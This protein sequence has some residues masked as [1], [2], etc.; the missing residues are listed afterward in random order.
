MV[1]TFVLGGFLWIRSYRSWDRVL[2]GTHGSGLT[3]VSDVGK[4][5]VEYSHSGSAFNFFTFDIGYDS[6][7]K[8]KAMNPALRGRRDQVSDMDYHVDLAWIGF[9][10]GST[11][12]SGGY[13]SPQLV[14]YDLY[15]LIPYWLI[16]CAAGMG[17]L[18]CYRHEAGLRKTEFKI[19]AY[20]TLTVLLLLFVKVASPCCLST[21]FL[22][23]TPTMGRYWES[24]RGRS[25]FPKGHCD[26]CGYDLRAT[27]DRCPECGTI[28]AKIPNLSRW[29]IRP[30]GNSRK[31]PPFFE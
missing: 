15:F 13:I 19:F 22:L 10:A 7:L 12:S 2:V 4:L 20:A 29:M 23:L 6:D 8:G 25:R 18:F 5:S 28:A 16:T 9:A 27:P 24:I 11:Y 21:F 26:R 14:P 31:Q 17:A 1:A 30:S 3:F